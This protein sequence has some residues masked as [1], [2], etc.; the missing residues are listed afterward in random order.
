MKAG[1]GPV[2]GQAVRG[3]SMLGTGFKGTVVTIDDRING[4][5]AVKVAVLR[6]GYLFTC[7]WFPSANA[8]KVAM[9]VATWQ[10]CWPA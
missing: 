2:L 8:A 10:A 9:G 5:P 6:E 4:A 3:T 7:L 1:D